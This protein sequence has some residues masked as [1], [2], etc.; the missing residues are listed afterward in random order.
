MLRAFDISNGKLRQLSIDPESIDKDSLSDVLWLDL[1]EADNREKGLVESTYQGTLPDAEDI[2]E[3]ETSARLFTDKTGVHVHSLFIYHS[4]GRAETASVAFTLNGNRLITAK[5]TELPD[6]RLLRMRCRRGLV[7]INSAIDLMLTLFSHKID[8]LADVLEDLYKSLN[9]VSYHVLEDDEAELGDAIDQLAVIEDTNGKVRLC[10]MDTQRSIS[11]ITRH[12]RNEPEALE[13]CREILRDIETL[14]AHS[15][16]VTDKVNFLMDS[17]Q[18]FINIEQNQIIKTFSIAAVVFLPPT[19]I[20]SIYGMNFTHM[21][22]LQSPY[23][24]PLA[25]LAMVLSGIAPYWFFK[26]KGWL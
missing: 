24:Y 26:R 10:L 22:E 23:A 1:T 7:R 11:F 5:D 14:L 25:L 4:E 12:I 6:F 3:I 13:T 18:G 17:T 9:G 19:L 16:F 2:E 15:M 21:P 20:A 8:H